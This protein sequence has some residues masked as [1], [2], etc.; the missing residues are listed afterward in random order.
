MTLA[1][2][3]AIEVRGQGYGNA[4]LA[5][6]PIEDVVVLDLPS[7]PRE[8]RSAVVA[9]ACGLS[10]ATAHLALRGAALPQ[11]PVVLD[12]LRARPGPRVVLGDLNLDAE[13][14][15]ADGFT[16]VDAPPT[17]PAK[18]PR[19][20]IDHVLLDGVIAEAVRVPVVPVSDHRPLVVD[21]SVP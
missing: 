1:F 3:P 7:P 12:A 8:P 5:R 14:V 16:L 2:G 15:E 4:L 21:V 11:V 17:W 9:R 6:G 18:A 10:I 13:V 20:R 19:R